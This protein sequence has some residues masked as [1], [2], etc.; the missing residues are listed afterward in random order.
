MRVIAHLSPEVRQFAQE[1]GVG[2]KAYSLGVDAYSRKSRRVCMTDVEA[3]VMKIYRGE[4]EPSQNA[5]A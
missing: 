4:E 2:G 1:A 5:V 3:Q